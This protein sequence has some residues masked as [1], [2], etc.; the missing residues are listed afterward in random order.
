MTQAA[1]AAD[2]PQMTQMIRPQMPQILIGSW[3]LLRHRKPGA[4]QFRRS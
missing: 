2:G 4:G 1:D 3:K